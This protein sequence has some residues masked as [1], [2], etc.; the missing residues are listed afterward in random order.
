[1][2]KGITVTLYK[3]TQTGT[4]AIGEPVYTEQAEQVHNVLVS[5]VSET[6]VLDRVDLAGGRAIY[7]LAIPKGDTHTWEDSV[8]EFF[9]EKWKTTGIPT[10][11]IEANIPL[12][13]NKKVTV[14]RYV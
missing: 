2:I 13:W 5:P 7:T 10:T 6:D 8:V 1:M 9:G 14:E 4:N 11:G 3:K 12:A